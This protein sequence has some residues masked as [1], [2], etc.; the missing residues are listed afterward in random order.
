MNI[1][2]VQYINYWKDPFNDRWLLYFIQNIFK[3]KYKV[4]EV[5]NKTTCDILISSIAG[6][7]HTVSNYTA[8]LKLFFTG[9]NVDRYPPYNNLHILQN[10][11]DLIVGFTPTDSNNKLIR[12]PLWL[13]YYPFYEMTH[14]THN[15]IDFIKNERNKNKV[16]HKRFFASCIS[17]HSRL[18]IRAKLSNK[19]SEYGKVIYPGTWRHNY[20]IG[21]TQLDKVRFLTEVKYNIC[22]ENS[23]AVGYHTE[24]IFHALEAGCVPIYWGVN[25]PEKNIIH[26]D[27][28][29]FINI[30]N[31]ML[32]DTQIKKAIDNYNTYIDAD[33]FVDGAKEVVSNY[34]KVLGNNI[35]KII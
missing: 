21:P 28:Y 23:K 32:L 30:E 12:F 7:I 27:C 9:E 19:M 35:K 16:I 25:M 14:D 20:S 26:P 6:P 1:L 31:D 2:T 3:H 18:G 33:I 24:K 17:R 4:I 8:K 34:Y 11:F 22:P 10:Y 5:K 15:I 29:Q 13:Q